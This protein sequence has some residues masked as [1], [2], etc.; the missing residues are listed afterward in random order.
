[1]ILLPMAKGI[2]NA[3]GGRDEIKKRAW[4]KRAKFYNLTLFSYGLKIN[5]PIYTNFQPL[6]PQTNAADHFP[7]L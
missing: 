3:C 7:G 6:H 1:M 5:A 2:D 4:I